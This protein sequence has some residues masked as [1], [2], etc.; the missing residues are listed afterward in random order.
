M[1]FCAVILV[2]YGMSQ[3]GS[4]DPT[5]NPTDLGFG[6]GDGAN[7]S[8]LSTA[9]Q[10]D[11]KIII[12]GYFETYN[13]ITVN[14][15]ARL[16]SD[17]TL[18]NA[19]DAGLGTDNA[20]RTISIQSDGKIIIGGDFLEVNG[21]QRNHIAR[22]NTNGTLDLTFNPGSGTDGFFGVL[23]TAIQ[24]DGKI[25]IGGDFT[26]FNNTP[27][28]GIARLNINGSLDM[29]FTVF[30]PD[31]DWGEIYKL[32]IQPDGK[33]LLGGSFSLY[34]SSNGNTIYN[35]ARLNINGSIDINFE[36]PNN[37]S[38]ISD[39]TIMTNG[40]IV[41][42]DNSNNLILS[43][44][45][46]DGTVD[47]TFNVGSGA[48]ESI[49]RIISTD[50]DKVIIG[51]NFT[52]Y[53][54]LNTPYV[55]RI[56]N[57]GSLDQ[58][59]FIATPLDIYSIDNITQQTDGGLIISS[60]PSLSYSPYA[61]G[62]T[63]YLFRVNSNGTEDFTFNPGNGAN[64]A[65]FSSIIQPDGKI[66]LV[67]SFTK[68]N[69]SNSYGIIRLNTNGSVDNTFNAGSGADHS[70]RCIALQADGKII[71]GG[72]FDTFNGNSTPRLA[73]L[74]SNGTLDNSFVVGAGFNS[75]INSV[76]IDSQG[77]ILVGGGFTTY[78]SETFNCL[79][80]LNSNGSVDMTFNI[81]S[82]FNQQVNSI[83]VKNDGKIIVGGTFSAFNNV[84]V[85]SS[86]LSLN[87]NG[88][89]DNTINLGDGFEEIRTIRVLDNQKIMLGGFFLSFTNFTQTGLKRLNADGSDDLSFNSS[90]S[91]SK[92][93]DI[94]V[95]SDGKLIVVGDFTT[96]GGSP[97]NG[98]ARIHVDGALDNTFNPG[99]GI[100]NY[101][102]V[103][104]SVNTV[105]LQADGKIV[106]GGNF[107]SYN[108]AGR[109]R[110][111][112]L[113]VDG[114]FVC[115]TVTGTDIISSCAPITWIDGN[116][117]SATNNTATFN[118]IGG[119]ANGCDSLVTLNFTLWPCT[120][121]R[122][123]DCGAT[124]VSMN[125]ILRAIQVGA[126]NYRFRVSGANNGGPGWNNN[127]FIYD[128]PNG[129]NHFR[130]QFIPGSAWGATYAVEVAVG[131]GFGNYGPYGN[132]CNVTL[133]NQTTTQVTA[134]TCG[135][136]VT[137][138][139]FVLADWAPGTVAY[140]FRIQG[141]NNGGAGWSGNTFIYETT[142]PV[143]S[144]KFSNHV[145][146]A[147]FGETY[148]IDV[149][150]LSGDNVWLPYGSAC[151][152]TIATPSTQIQASQCGATG[153]ALGTSVL[154]DNVVGASGYRFRITGA[155]SASWM[156]DQFILNR[157][158]R[159]MQFQ[160][161][162]GVLAGEVYQIEV[163]VMDANGNYGA[164]GTPCNITLAG[165]PAIVINEENEIFMADKSLVELAFGA[166]ASHNPFTTEFGIQALNANDSETI[167]VVIYDMNGKLIERYTVNPIDI[168]NAKFGSN[169]ASGMYMIEVR[170]GAN[171][172]VIR[173][174]KN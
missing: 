29:T 91:G 93:Y 122:A 61:D 144:F 59:F 43:R 95:Q 86:V 108:G 67:G 111:A 114:A 170:Q 22:L 73:R 20:V 17:G 138:Y 167:N 13:G 117:Y 102:N 54:N 41:V 128:T 28:L 107:T 76:V 129:Q 7:G 109:N 27:R 57:D 4:N 115:E 15:I 71:I 166:N 168:E 105:L 38:Y 94:D 172:A 157:P 68:F 98:I 85:P 173:Q 80:R 132:S 2:N 116:N 47:G 139:N 37:F 66:I 34:D 100:Y 161:V 164:Y 163:A 146:G 35:L 83:A 162:A 18:D 159:V 141:A 133:E 33:I 63:K 30:D 40:K 42:I 44:L 153:V 62:S 103:F 51:G 81:G 148:S 154:A 131:D 123:I 24:A 31:F 58:S 110:V 149:A 60:V 1:L 8:V 55:A 140:R 158:N 39:F 174:V 87:P 52:T 70:I 50:N 151:N 169:L 88:T 36:T 53:D 56:N 130:F 16:N 99:A 134:A 113:L 96:F 127:Q 25:L 142:A 171:Q 65:I 12:G 72:D 97:R 92:V 125:Q 69:N 120:Q 3:P 150:V 135:T 143:R 152:V 160:M 145:P 23:T 6:I 118:I 9:V 89:L 106:I 14:H 112:R 75:S 90:S 147:L 32:K 165:T 19:F 84:S 104:T 136:T 155:N 11:G 10:V 64:S 79:L 121:L 124:N 77:K 74:N 21:V 78:D 137:M 156:N 101:L 126:P 49:T 45:N 46:P 26:T 119:A 5:F 48:N 82:G